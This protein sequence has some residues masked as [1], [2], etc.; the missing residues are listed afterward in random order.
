MVTGIAWTEETWNPLA[1][2]TR[3]SAGCDLGRL[4]VVPADEP[5][6]PALVIKAREGGSAATGA[7]ERRVCLSRVAKA[8]TWR[9]VMSGVACAPLLYRKV[10]RSVVRLV[11]VVVVDLLARLQWATN[12]FLGHQSML[13]D[14]ASRVRSRMIGAPDQHVTVRSD[15]A[16][17]LPVGVL[18]SS[19]L[20]L[21]ECHN[22]RVT[23]RNQ[24]RKG[25]M[26]YAYRNF[27]D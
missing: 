24:L 26:P 7:G 25:V 14:V 4:N 8:T 6:R 23:H 12:R 2:C 3:V 10:L 27:V 11:P 15:R 13:V 9:S 22:Y 18:R 17:T 21:L 16:A 5:A 1:G 20:P 19:I